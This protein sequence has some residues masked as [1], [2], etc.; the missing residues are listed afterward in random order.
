MILHWRDRGLPW[1]EFVPEIK[2][3]LLRGVNVGGANRLAMPEFR[4]MLEEL[5]LRSALAARLAIKVAVP[6]TARNQRSSEAIAAMAQGI[7]A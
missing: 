4:T 5:G 7:A 3:L 2:V 1:D 6:M